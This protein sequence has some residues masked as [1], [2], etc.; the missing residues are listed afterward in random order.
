M[1]QQLKDAGVTDQGVKTYPGQQ[2]HVNNSPEATPATISPEQRAEFERLSGQTK[3][4]GKEQPQE[5]GQKDKG[6]EDKGQA[7]EDLSK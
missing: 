3:Q 7:H 6:Q 4:D 2:N 5:H 1:A